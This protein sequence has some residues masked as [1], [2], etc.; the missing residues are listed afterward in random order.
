MSKEIYISSTPHETRLA[1]VENDELTEIYY[2]RENEYTLAGSIYNGKVTRVL[3]GM[4][5]S[6]VDIGL[7]RDAFLYITDFMEEAGDSADFDHGDAAPR[8]PRTL[9]GN[10]DSAPREG[11][12]REGGNRDRGNRNDRGD[13]DRN[14]GYVSE[15]NQE[16]QSATPQGDIAQASEGR[17]GEFG[18][19][20]ERNDRGGRG[21]GRGRGRG[22]RGDRQPQNGDAPRFAQTPVEAPRELEPRPVLA[23]SELDES[24]ATDAAIG[25]GA[26]GADGSRRWRGRRGRRRG[27]GG[28]RP[29]GTPSTDAILAPGAPIEPAF[30][31][32]EFD[33]PA[34]F[35]IDGSAAPVEAAPV[36]E[37]ENFTRQDRPRG[38]RSDRNGRDRGN[39]NDRGDRGPRVPRGFAPRGSYIVDGEPEQPIEAAADLGPAIEPLILPGESLGKYRKGDDQASSPQASSAP[40]APPVSDFVVSGWDGGAVLP[41]ETI[42][43]RSG[44]S[45]GGSTGG[46]SDRNDRTDRND[47]GGRDRGGRDG[48]RDGRDR[49]RG[50]RRDN[51]ENYAEHS[52]PT[53]V[54]SYVVPATEPAPDLQSGGP[55]SGYAHAEETA[56]H[57]IAEPVHNL[58]E[59]TVE[60][61]HNE[62]AETQPVET[63]ELAYAEPE[64]P[65]VEQEYEPEEA[66][67]S[68]R[69]DPVA[70]S[71]FRQSAPPPPE[72]EA[73]PEPVQH[74]EV[75]PSGEVFVPEPVHE[76][77]PEHLESLYASEAPAT[78]EAIPADQADEDTIPEPLHP[79]GTGNYRAD[80]EV[81]PNVTTIEPSGDMLSAA[82][83]AEAAP[84]PQHFAPG[85]GVL[86]EDFLEEE[87]LDT[88]HTLHAHA[89]EDLE[90]DAEQEPLDNAADLGTMIREMSID[91]IT[92]TEPTIEEDDEDFEEDTL[93][94]DA[95]QDSEL[96]D[97]E[98]FEEGQEEQSESS[99]DQPFSQSADSDPSYANAEGGE[100]RPEGRI[101]SS[102]NGDVR[103]RREGGRGRDRDRGR[104]GRDRDRNSGNRE[105]SSSS[106]DRG[107]DRSSDR[108]SDRDRSG[109]GERARNTGGSGDRD[110]GRSNRSGGRQSMQ[111]T[112]LP[113]I[114]D[115]LKPGQELLCQIAKEPIA[116][117]GARITSHIALPGRFLVFMPTVAHTGVSRKIESDGER[118]R[119]K[120][121]LLSEKG[122]AAGGFIVRTAA[123]GASE[124]EL[125]SDLRFLLN[126][127][128]DIKTR[129]ESSKS[130]ALIYHDLNLVERILRDQ[131]TD[132]FSAI[133]V[134]TETDYERILRFLQRFQP[135]LIR[136]VKL[137]SKETPLFEQFGITEEINKALRSKVWL[138]S[139]GSIVIN[140]TEALVAIDINTGKFVGK[141]A[142]LE[143]TI[144]KTNLDAIPE[145]VRQ[146]RLRDLGGIIIIDFIDMDER[147]NRNRVM[148]ALEDELKNDR[149]PS[150]VL[151]FNDFG[152]VAITRK[153]VKQS[154]ERTLSTTCNVCTGTGMV[155][156]PITVCN[157]IYIEMRKMHKHLDRGD[158]MLRV[159]PD[160]VK[161][162]KVSG[163]KW[164]QEMEEMC[165]KT[166]LIKSDPS[167][168][169]E[170][171]DIH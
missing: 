138:K 167:L 62:A 6:F 91:H 101:P 47:R 148:Q 156:S 137:Y 144:V 109:L 84:E 23:E 30:E 153:R 95:F 166:I 69:I 143:D 55:V 112:N 9:E 163:S 80:S 119:L 170:Q 110:R 145:I 29:E 90:D 27:R 89:Y 103:R 100:S 61:P 149:A 82:P 16:Q 126:L 165:G 140:Q 106:P 122:D 44:G 121:I 75:A 38:D 32:E 151:P 136:R 53:P 54:A 79:E 56:Q 70:P 118:R 14:A 117:K 64:Q 3:P 5:S 35:D 113:A 105:G 99:E 168:H 10:R 88:A 162:L 129:S 50:P 59:P 57:I 4:Q 19:N 72:V 135:S 123:A 49:D 152:L 102:P 155:K 120:E 28:N 125:R 33:E 15:R 157:D 67:A 160:V 40:A 94:E 11:G 83:V 21:R 114:S 1:I 71:E 154:L 48:R 158:V 51:R 18:G 24:P 74:L 66:S 37:P 2:E 87:E 68:Y 8:A 150:K 26:P 127:W 107:S 104:G 133:W 96:G 13:R 65:K 85:Q 130:P 134:D 42:R 63:V 116:K 159:H 31:A 17:E 142:R 60:H 77:T 169:P 46:F 111:A 161:Q 139:G 131:V 12:N 97:D 171:F 98:E 147:K 52:A 45:T 115:L 164:L 22:D 34:T 146:I 78:E 141:T 93:E 108:G 128:A 81:E 132:N 41:G 20:R 124:E 7:E 39:R 43:P 36:A 76:A 73:A 86:E 58:P 92:R 25:E